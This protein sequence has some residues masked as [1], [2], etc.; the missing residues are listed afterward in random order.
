MRTPLDLPAGLN[1]DDTVYGA[2]GRWQAC[3][4]MRFRNGRPQT[5][6][7]WESLASELLSGVCRWAYPWT[8]LSAV[9]NIGFGTHSNLQVWRNGDLQDI[10]PFGPP[11]RLGTDPLQV[12]NGTPR[13]D[14]TFTAH[15][16]TTGVEVQVSNAEVVGA[17]TP[18]GTFTITVDDAD[19]F[20]FTFTSNATSDATGG[21]SQIVVTPQT[22]LPAGATDGT[23]SVGYGT[24]AFGLGPWGET[25]VT[26]DYFPRTWSGGAWGQQLLA[27]PRGGGVYVW[28]N[29]LMQPAVVVPQ[30]PTQI[31]QLLIA[32]MNGG[33]QAFA[34]GCNEEVSGAFNPSCIRHCSVRD[35]T[36][37]LQS[38]DGSTAREYTLEGGGRIVGGR[39]IGPYMAVWTTDSLFL[40]TF[41]GSLDEVW[42]FD[43]V[44]RNCG[45]IGPNAAVVA[46]QTAYWASPDRQFYAYTPG[47]QP[48]IVPCQIRE[49]YAENLAAAQADKIAAATT[50]EFGEVR[51]H[52][53]DA[54]DGFENSRFVRICVAGDQRDI[55]AW[56]QG[57]LAR[58]AYVDAGPALYP[59]GVTADGHIY[60]H[61]RGKSA[62]GQSF[63][64]Y[65]RTAAQLIDDDNRLLVRQVWPDFQNQVGSVSIDVTAQERAQGDVVAA[66][67]V[68]VAK[69]QGKADV[70][71]SGCIFQIQFSGQSAPTY[72]RIGRP[73]FETELDGPAL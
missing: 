71:I 39:M 70:L 62:D 38:V 29:D 61:E 54:R 67:T 40:G 6:G 55:G 33:Y 24:G 28:T 31:T 10:T 56:S 47:G 7:G 41:I 22:V 51:W 26:A 43:R 14:V 8:D 53:P 63:A 15:G 35:Y 68:M 59:V 66:P 11:T 44:A 25:P 36:S 13:V 4:L 50:G 69:G 58:T 37:W 42:R 21:G 65:I 17:I 27:S 23:G 30:A 34:L 16:F 18:N 48:Q 72:V 2:Q 5:D 57:V 64:W 73:A 32:P 46:G 52:Y 3:S 1:G 12:H 60:Y 9:L 45:L 20:H 19:H 49:E